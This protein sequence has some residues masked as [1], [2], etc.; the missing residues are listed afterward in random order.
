VRGVPEKR[1]IFMRLSEEEPK[2]L[3][4]GRGNVAPG[5][6]SE[7]LLRIERILIIPGSV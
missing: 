5:G 1:G 7:I 6:P 3:S 4:R 2:Y